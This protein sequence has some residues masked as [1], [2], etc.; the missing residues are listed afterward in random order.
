MLKSGAFRQL[1]RLGH[2]RELW[3]RVVPAD[4]AEHADPLSLKG[5]RLTV[6]VNSPAVRFTLERELRDVLLRALQSSPHGRDVREIVFELVG[7]R[8]PADPW[9]QARRSNRGKS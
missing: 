2:L 1:L 8:G 5:G 6:A 4:L 3:T 9:D 7:Q